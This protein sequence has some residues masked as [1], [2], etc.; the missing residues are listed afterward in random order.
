MMSVLFHQFILMASPSLW[1]RSHSGMQ[2]LRF[3]GTAWET[4]GPLLTAK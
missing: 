2:M 4:T 3:N 1:S